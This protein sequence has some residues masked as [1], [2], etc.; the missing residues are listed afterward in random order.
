LRSR[1]TLAAENLFVLAQ[2]VVIVKPATLIRW[3]QAAFRRFWPWKSNPVGRPPVSAEVRRLIRRMSAE[4]RTWDEER[5]ADD[6]AQ[7]SSRNE[8]VASDNSTCIF[9]MKVDQR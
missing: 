4:N 8:E 1:A 6:L 3:H 9:R 2:R 7:V 5:I